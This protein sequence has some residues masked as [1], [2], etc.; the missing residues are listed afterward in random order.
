MSDV[1]GATTW[2]VVV[3]GAGPAGLAAAGT[4]AQLGAEVLLLDEQAAPGGQIYRNMGSTS[5][6]QQAILG[7][8]YAHGAY[9]LAALEE[10][11]LHYEPDATVWQ[12]TG[13]RE[14]FYSVDGRTSHV[15][16]R[17]LIIAT[18]ALERPTPIEGWTLP[19]V[20]TAGAMQTLLKSA[21]VPS[22]RLVLA[23]SG[24]LLLLL[25]LQLQRAGADVARIVD[26]TPRS[27][28]WRA[29]AYLPHALRGY[30]YLLKGVR[31]L[32]ELERSRIPRTLYAEGLSAIGSDAGVSAL[33]FRAR[34]HWHTEACDL[35]LLH[36]GVVPNVQISR[37][38]RAE[39]DW[40]PVGRFWRP[41]LDTTCQSTL[42]GIA[43]A[44]DGAGIGG[45][46][47]AAYQ[48]EVAACG[49]LARL[50]ADHDHVTAAKLGRA[51]SM[52]YSRHLAARPWLDALFAPATECLTPPDDVLVCRCEEVTA[53]TV[54]EL[55]RGGC[56]GPNQLKAFS[57]AGMGPCQGRY[58]G[59]TVCELLAEVH[60]TSPADVGY[61]RLRNPVKPVTVADLA[62]ID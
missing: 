62:N 18:G 27:N 21:M 3:I 4:A 6:R 13:E 58:C 20:M 47:A 44:G 17:Q 60:E 10:P 46:L 2:D 56:L 37:A 50:Q 49:A 53:G 5:A 24:P 35:L 7:E 9:L 15:L 32:R 42:P 11:N 61:Y 28:V 29:A 40:D 36:Q 33:R 48:G 45:A 16:A 8:D 55:A 34:G 51:A 57:R 19:G 30:D 23:G 43:F 26:T 22:G 52:A 39:H 12:V 25:A 38:L 14:V 1:S 59:L 54:R 31:M 41:L